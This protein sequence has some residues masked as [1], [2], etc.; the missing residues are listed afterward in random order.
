MSCWYSAKSS[1]RQRGIPFSI[2]ADEVKELWC[3]AEVNGLD[4]RV[5]VRKDVTLGYTRHN[6]EFINRKK[7]VWVPQVKQEIPVPV[8]VE[9]EKDDEQGADVGDSQG[10]GPDEA[11]QTEVGM[12]DGGNLPG[13]SPPG[14]DNA[15]GD[16]GLSD[17][18][19]EGLP[20]GGPV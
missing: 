10:L 11:V 1:A 5:M 9:G 18:P 3:V 15:G 16:E 2:T 6:C 8:V 12:G 20:G 14:D 13:D 19:N 4:N 17:N 7:A